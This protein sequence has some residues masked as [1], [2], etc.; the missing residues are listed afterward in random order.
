M[1]IIDFLKICVLLVIGLCN[2]CLCQNHLYPNISESRLSEYP[3]LKVLIV[4]HSHTD[5]GWKST[6][7]DYYQQSVKNILDSAFD[8]L[9]KDYTKYFTFAEIG[10]FKIWWE[11]QSDLKRA[12]FRKLVKTGRWEFVNGGISMNDQAC[13]YYEDIIQN[14]QLGADFLR[15]TF[16]IASKSGWM[17]D[18]FG[19]SSTMSR[20]YS[21]MGY[22]GLAISQVNHFEEKNLVEKQ[23][24]EQ[25]WTPTPKSSLYTYLFLDYN[26]PPGFS[27]NHQQSEPEDFE[28]FITT[29][30]LKVKKLKDMNIYGPIDISTKK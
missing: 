1:K 30:P 25:I 7:A 8:A 3:H 12:K 9:E 15:K 10:F 5:L 27:Y 6:M 29:N 24:M 16:D 20:F 18:T 21:Q 19:H 13:T 26:F 4:L 22:N 2:L 28:L 23:E 14:Y 17:I 11:E